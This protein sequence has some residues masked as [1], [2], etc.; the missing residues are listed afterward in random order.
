MRAPL[1]PSASRTL[2]SRCRLMARSSSRL[3]TLTHAISST[4]ATAPSNSSSVGR[5][6]PTIDSSSGLTPMPMSLFV[7]RELRREAGGDHPGLGLRLLDRHAGLQPPDRAPAAIAAR[8]H[9]RARALRPLV[10]ERGRDPHL[11][12]LRLDRE[13]ES[14]GH[15]ADDGEARVVEVDRAADHARRRRRTAPASVCQ[16]RIAGRPPGPPPAASSSGRNV[17]PDAGETPSNGNRSAV[18]TVPRSSCA[19]RSPVSVRLML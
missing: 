18:T 4:N 9:D 11:R 13:P 7:F 3:A 12:R 1:A 19:S 6:L 14:G 10:V 2:I 5:R 17:R 8:H 15:H 16:L